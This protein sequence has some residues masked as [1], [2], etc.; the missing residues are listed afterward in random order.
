MGG[1]R[2]GREWEGGEGRRR[3]GEGRQGGRGEFAEG[4][5]SVFPELL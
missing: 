5:S 1:Q 4:K 3:Q 2:R